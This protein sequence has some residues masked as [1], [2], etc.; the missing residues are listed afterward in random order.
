LGDSE[1]NQYEK[2]CNDSQLNGR[3]TTPL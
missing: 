3:G 2:R 1:E